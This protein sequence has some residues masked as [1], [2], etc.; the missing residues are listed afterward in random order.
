MTPEEAAA[1]FCAVAAGP[2]SKEAVTRLRALI[3]DPR[4]QTHLVTARPVTK[5][6]I[7]MCQ[8]EQ[9]KQLLDQGDHP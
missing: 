3:R 4:Y 8:S 6:C 9:W 2:P 1:E 5:A 7:D